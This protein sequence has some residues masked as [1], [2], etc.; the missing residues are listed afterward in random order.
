[1]GDRT[2]CVADRAAFEGFYRSN[3]A[4]VVR[5]CAL[6]LLDRQGAEDVAAEAFARLWSKWGQI[7]GEDHAGGFV[8]K[9]AMRLCAKRSR[10]GGR[11]RLVGTLERRAPDE[12]ARALDRRDVMTALARLPIR[13]R[14]AVVLRD[15][16]GFETQ[17]V[18]GMLGV[19]ESTVRVH[20]ARGRQAL[21]DSLAV[22][23]REG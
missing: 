19:R 15:W 22:E 18:A 6:V 3:L 14:Q 11:E 16:A 5:A 17:E 9:T 2:G 10:V 12:I 13:Q 1:V 4:R 20:L 23:E 8:F 21:R 7:E